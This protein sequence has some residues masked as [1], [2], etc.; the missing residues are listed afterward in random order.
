MNTSDGTQA[1]SDDTSSSDSTTDE[2]TGKTTTKYVK[3]NNYNGILNIRATPAKDGEVVG[4]L[5]HTESVEV[6]S[7]EN[8]WAS[9]MYKGVKCYV[10][11]E[12]L[13]DKKPAYIAPPTVTP[14]PAITPTPKPGSVTVAPEI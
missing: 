7:I 3:L 8:G 12:F 6:I 4:F 11:A 5:V 10:S 13:V 9:F 1:S 14:T 2:F